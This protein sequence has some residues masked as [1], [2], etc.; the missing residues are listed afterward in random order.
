MIVIPAEAGIQRTSVHKQFYVYILANKPNGTLYTGV[1]SNLARRIWEHKQELV[2]GFTKKYRIK[3]LVYFELHP[4]SESAITR[5]KQIK[6][7]RRTW[8]VDLIEETNPEWDDLSYL[9]AL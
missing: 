6:K 3:H 2:E 9:I 4:T 7:W 8:K 5:E 1:T